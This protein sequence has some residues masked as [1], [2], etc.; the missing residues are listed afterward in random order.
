M[1]RPQLFLLICAFAHSPHAAIPSFGAVQVRPGEAAKFYVVPKSAPPGMQDICKKCLTNSAEPKPSVCLLIVCKAP[2]PNARTFPITSPAG[3]K[4]CEDCSQI[5][6]LAP[7]C[8]PRRCI[9]ESGPTKVDTTRA[10]KSWLEMSRI[11]AD[12]LR[13]HKQIS[14]DEYRQFLDSYRQDWKLLTK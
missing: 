14:A 11:G 1:K 8:L 3:A 13:A 12:N 5:P 10:Y 2:E 9:D 6:G 4:A 7:V